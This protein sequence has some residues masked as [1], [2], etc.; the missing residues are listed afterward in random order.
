VTGV[1]TDFVV[2]Y[3]KEVIDARQAES[4]VHSALSDHAYNKEFFKI[5]P[6]LKGLAIKIDSFK[7]RIIQIEDA[8]K[9]IMKDEDETRL[10]E[11]SVKAQ[12]LECKQLL[13]HHELEVEVCVD[14]FN[15]EFK[16]I[17]EQLAIYSD[18]VKSGSY[19]D[20][21]EILEIVLKD[22]NKLK[23]II[24]VNH[25]II[26][27]ISIKIPARLNELI[28]LYNDM[29][30]QGYPLYHIS[31][32]ATINSVK[33]S[34]YNAIEFLKSLTVSIT[35]K[36]S[37]SLNAASNWSLISRYTGLSSNFSEKK[38]EAI[39]SFHFE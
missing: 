34:V 17:D 38:C 32:I 12:L 13:K 18:T 35:L 22:I 9:E 31:G 11:E 14:E 24:E 27:E 30:N 8:L 36:S 15:V 2:A 7:D 21:K 33:D 39:N 16:K 5:S 29:Q 1:P 25:S 19:N 23:D 4:K 3:A 10:L 28:D 20:A 6:I 37:F 26:S